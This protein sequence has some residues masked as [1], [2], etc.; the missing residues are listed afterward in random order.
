M[1]GLFI[2]L[3]G[4]DGCGKSTQAR[5][6]AEWLRS[7]GYEVILTDEPTDGPIGRFIRKILNGEIRTS[8]SAEVNLFAADRMWH[9]GNVILPALGDGKIVISERYVCSSIV[10]QTT[11]GAS[12]KEIL[13]ANKFAPEPDLSILIDTPPEVSMRRMNKKLDEFEKDLK[14]QKSVRLRYLQLAK[15]GKLKLV[16]G[17]L[18]ADEVQNEIR[19]LVQP[20]LR[21]L[22][23]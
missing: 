12:L 21:C 1:R 8:I 9:L 23:A 18:S 6:L 10:Y 15:N 20:M 4:I 2:V 5:M 14:L 7:E 19:K 22:S 3:E 11:R 16:N 17:T 13:A